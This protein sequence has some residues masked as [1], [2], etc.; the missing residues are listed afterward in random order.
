MPSSL[1]RRLDRV[2]RT[3]Y[4]LAAFIALLAL[5]GWALG[6]PRLRDLGADFAPM[7]PAEALAYL[8]LAISFY[9]SHRDDYRSRRAAYSAA[10]VA[11]A[12][13][14]FALVEGVSGEPPSPIDEKH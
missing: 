1:L 9:V 13:A 8:L 3:A 7:P 2:S 4:G 10:A 6:V 12:I 11:A 5:L 14:L